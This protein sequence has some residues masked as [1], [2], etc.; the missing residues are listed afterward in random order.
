MVPISSYDEYARIQC[1]GCA[2]DEQFME[3][4]AMLIDTLMKLP[5]APTHEHSASS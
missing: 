5:D 2:D 4:K 1:V 3:E